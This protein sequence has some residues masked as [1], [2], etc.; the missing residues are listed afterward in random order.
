MNR[1]KYEPKS[2]ARM[3][4]IRRA[5]KK[6]EKIGKNLE[7]IV[8]LSRRSNCEYH[9][10]DVVQIFEYIDQCLMATKEHLIP[11]ENHE[12]NEVK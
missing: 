6:A 12:V 7:K 4:F 1:P 8:D 3:R 2:R 11:G 10:E 9:E 5:S